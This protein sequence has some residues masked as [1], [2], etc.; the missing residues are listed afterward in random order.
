MLDR[1][2]AAL[3]V[4][5]GGSR[6]DVGNVLPASDASIA[7][8]TNIGGRD[9]AR[10]RGGS[11]LSQSP[12]AAESAHGVGPDEERRDEAIELGKW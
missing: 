4:R 1:P 2:L 5:C 3:V 10:E 7:R 6:A 9:L 8:V 11:N 12:V